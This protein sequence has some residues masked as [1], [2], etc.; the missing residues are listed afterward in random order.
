MFVSV[1]Y[2]ITISYENSHHKILFLRYSGRQKNLTAKSHFPKYGNFRLLVKSL[3]ATFGKTENFFMKKSL[4]IPAVFFL[5]L[6]TLVTAYFIAKISYPLLDF[7]DYN[8]LPIANITRNKML[9]HIWPS[10]KKI[11]VD[12][13]SLMIIPEFNRKE[14]EAI[15]K[16]YGQKSPNANLVFNFSDNAKIICLKLNGKAVNYHLA[17]NHLIIN[18]GRPDSVFSLQLKYKIKPETG[19]YFYEKE[20]EKYLFTINEPVFAPEWFACNDTPRD[21]FFLSLSART[22]KNKTVISNGRKT[23]EQLLGKEKITHWRTSYPIA[24]FSVALNIGKYVL[25]EEKTE[26]VNIQIYSYPKDKAKAGNILDLAKN[27]LH[28][29]SEKFGDFPFSKDKLSI[30]E[31]NWNYGGMENQTA[32]NI[33]EKF[34]D[35]ASFKEIIVHEIAH[36]WFGNCV[37]VSDWDDIWINEGLATY[38]EALYWES[39]AGPDGYNA[40]INSLKNFGNEKIR[41]REKNIFARVVYDKGAFIFHEIRKTTGKE[42]FFEALNSYIEKNKYSSADFNELK[43]YLPFEKL[44]SELLNSLK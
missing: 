38:C 44:P 7:S 39:V 26:N 32:I 10:Q 35:A 22:E 3:S 1:S 16:I 30:I 33:G 8:K 28:V 2:F 20:N 34:F 43:K 24:S 6:T 31:T 11:N 41:A 17:N 5:T 13:I 12:S 23:G 9:K 19:V 37:S 36:E 18:S 14:I 27:A 4:K 42:K 25:S 21:K 40:A 29:F 15:E